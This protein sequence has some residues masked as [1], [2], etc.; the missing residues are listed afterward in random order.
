M[1]FIRQLPHVEV[2]RQISSRK[3]LRFVDSLGIINPI[4]D[5]SI[6]L[7]LVFMASIFN[8]FAPVFVGL[9]GLIFL[10]IRFVKTLNQAIGKLSSVW[11]E[12]DGVGLRLLPLVSIEG[13]WRC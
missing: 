10:V 5:W 13:C 2:Q 11:C 6:L 3:I 12:V 1:V 7:V 4:F 8:L 9:V